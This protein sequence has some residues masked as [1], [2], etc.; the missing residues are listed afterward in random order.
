MVDLLSFEIVSDHRH[1]L[2]T[3]R[4]CL[5]DLS[6]TKTSLYTFPVSSN[7]SFKVLY[8]GN[9]E[10]TSGRSEDESADSEKLGVGPKNKPIDSVGCVDEAVTAGDNID[11][12][13]DIAF[14]GTIECVDEAGTA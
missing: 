8:F 12:W 10:N 7:A 14:G 11:D 1:L 5:S 2:L 3:V 6:F 4:K 9:E 13:P